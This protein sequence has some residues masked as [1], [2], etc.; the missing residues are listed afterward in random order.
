M[1]AVVDE[2]MDGGKD[3]SVTD[4]NVART[5]TKE[6]EQSWRIAGW[7]A[8]EAFAVACMIG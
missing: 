8:N 5:A 2:R 3:I 6:C 4:P 1:V 7:N